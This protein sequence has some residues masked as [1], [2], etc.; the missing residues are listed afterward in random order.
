MVIERSGADWGTVMK[1]IYMVMSCCNVPE[2]F[3]EIL[4]LFVIV[5]NLF[6]LCDVTFFCGVLLSENA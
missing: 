6:I 4:V 2:I 5:I 1:Q 3:I